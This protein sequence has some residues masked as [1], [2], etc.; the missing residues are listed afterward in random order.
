MWSIYICEKQQRYGFTANEKQCP[1]LSKHMNINDYN[2]TMCGLQHW[3]KLISY[4]YSDKRLVSKGKT[5]R[6]KICRFWQS[7]SN[8]FTWHK[9]QQ[10]KN[11]L[12]F[13]CVC[14]NC[15]QLITHSNEIVPPVVNANNISLFHFLINYRPPRKPS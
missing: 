10:K 9:V 1:Q 3:A 4:M 13:V 8:I 2:S 15:E 7:V 14:S 11:Y 5:F 12:I 6:K